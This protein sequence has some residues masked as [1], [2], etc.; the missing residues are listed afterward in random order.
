M[1]TSFNL[2]DLPPELR[3]IIWDFAIYHEARS[4]IIL[5]EEQKILPYKYLCSPFLSV[6][7]ESRHF[8][9]KLYSVG[10]GVSNIKI[11]RG[12][13]RD[14]RCDY[15]LLRDRVSLL[16]RGDLTSLPM[17]MQ[18]YHSLTRGVIYIS[19]ETDNFILGNF[20]TEYVPM[21]SSNLRCLD[22]EDELQHDIVLR[23]ADKLPLEVCAQVQN[24]SHPI[25]SMWRIQ[26]GALSC[27]AR[28]FTGVQG[29]KV[30][31]I[32]KHYVEF[33]AV[34]YDVPF[35]VK[36]LCQYESTALIDEITEEAEL[37][38]EDVLAHDI[39]QL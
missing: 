9:R 14:F 11:P 26:I 27:Q 22:G 12:L 35:I 32:S 6:N 2:N 20:V 30:I 18:K 28:F 4:R 5:I 23:V 31:R 8:A 24:L 29:Y 17:R 19:P 38:S 39:R 37:V 16:V 13:L 3:A 36:S 15:H 1:A 10:I 25:P 34:I 33:D 7:S 21:I